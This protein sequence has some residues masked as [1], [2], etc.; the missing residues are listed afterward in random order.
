MKEEELKQLREQIRH[1]TGKIV[2]LAAERSKLANEIGRIKKE[3][4]IPIQDEGTELMLE[5]Y[6]ISLCRESG[7]DERTGLKILHTLIEGSKDVQGYTQNEQRITPMTMAARARKLISEGRD[8]IRLDIGEPDFGPPK[9]VVEE[10]IRALNLGKTKYTDTR[11]IPPLIS[12]LQNYIESKHKFGTQSENLLITPGGRFA[13][14]AALSAIVREGESVLIIQPCWPAYRENIE[15][16]GARTISL[17][18][19]IDEGWNPDI[20][21]LQQSITETTRAIIISYPSNPTGKII[22]KSM[23]KAILEIAK[24]KNITIISD[25]IYNEYAYK[26][27]PSILDFNV[28]NFV[29]TSSFSKTWAMTGFRVGYAVSSREIIQKM[30]RVLALAVTCVPEFIQYGAVKALTSEQDARKNSETM[31]RRIEIAYSE[32]SKIEQLKTYKPDGAM[33]LFPVSRDEK[34]DSDN[35]AETLLENKG[36]TVS[37]GTGFGDYRK[38]FRISLGQKEERIVEGIRRIGELLG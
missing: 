15:F 23:F 12:A 4:G 7:F 24:E 9:E 2:S 38:A 35:F 6:V 20:D 22:D 18:T 29:L 8:I 21:R 27:C 16:V 11:G 14:F 25:E 17:R 3:M 5:K 19:E 31:K 37:P 13:I 1:V 10:C 30:Y 33:Y 26:D 32:I 28:D 34:F 36:V